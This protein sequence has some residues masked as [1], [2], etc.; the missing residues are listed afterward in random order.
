[1]EILKECPCLNQYYYK[2][3]SSYLN[4]YLIQKGGITFQTWKSSSNNLLT[5]EHC[6]TIFFVDWDNAIVLPVG[7]Y[8]R[9]RINCYIVFS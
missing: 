3:W 9:K 7:R 2:A 6:W 1:M 4:V 5:Q 8:H